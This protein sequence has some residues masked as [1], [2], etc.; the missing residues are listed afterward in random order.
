[1]KRD[2]VY[3]LILVFILVPFLLPAQD[4]SGLSIFDTADSQQIEKI[5]TSIPLPQIHPE[6]LSV[7]LNNEQM[8][9]FDKVMFWNYMS[10]TALGINTASVLVA[11]AVDPLV[12]GILSL[13]SFT[14]WTISTGCMSF[15]YRDLLLDKDAPKAFTF[16]PDAPPFKTGAFAALGAYSFGIG[17]I[18]A[19]GLSFSDETGAATVLAYICSGISSISGIIAIVQTFSYSK[20]V[21]YAA[22]KKQLAYSYNASYYRSIVTPDP[23]PEEKGSYKIALP[24]LKFSF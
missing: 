20:D 1:M 14:Y 10:I 17:T 19:I 23:K 3:M 21:D 16:L 4:L 2:I 11:V 9:I 8:A 18:T 6:L 24:L 7:S 5:N 15:S 13:L 12:G 22:Y